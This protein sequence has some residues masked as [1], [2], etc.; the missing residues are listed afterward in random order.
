MSTS[1]KAIVP[2][3]PAPSTI[4]DVP[5]L[6]I[7]VVPVNVA[8]PSILVSVMPAPVTFKTVGAAIV[9]DAPEAMFERLMP[10][11]P[12]KVEAPFSETAPPLSRLSTSSP[13][14]LSV[15]PPEMAIVPPVPEI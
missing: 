11:D 15:I 9:T 7:V 10:C 3:L 4:P 8:E 6:A 12:P 1:P 14:P 2:A 5:G 13:S